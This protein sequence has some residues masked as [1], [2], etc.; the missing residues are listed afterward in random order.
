MT[1]SGH[2]NHVVD[3]H[4]TARAH[5]KPALNAGVKV[6]RHRYVAV[7]QQRDT[8]LFQFREPAFRNTVCGGH[9]PKVARFVMCRVLLRLVGEQHLNNHFARALGTGGVGGND[10]AFA[11]LTDAGGRQRALT[12]DLDHTGAT[13]PVRAIPRGRLVAQ[14]WDH[15][16]ASVCD[17]PDCHA[18]LCLNRFAVQSECDFVAH[19]A[20]LPENSRN[21]K[22]KMRRA[23]GPIPTQ[24]AGFTPRQ[25]PIGTLCVLK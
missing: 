4:L 14:M 12:L 13:V 1:A 18:R 21:Y 3:L 6:N 7:V 19:H 24:G 8:A 17:F 16:A 9:V 10:H 20:V 15:E 11:G 23:G 25:F 22:S 2:A 5:A